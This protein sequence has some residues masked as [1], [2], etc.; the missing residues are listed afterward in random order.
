MT[1]AKATLAVYVVQIVPGMRRDKLDARATNSLNM[2]ENAALES[3]KRVDNYQV[4]TGAR[5]DREKF[6]K[7]ITNQRCELHFAINGI[8]PTDMPDKKH[9]PHRTQALSRPDIRV[10]DLLHLDCQLQQVSVN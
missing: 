8:K 4:P 10:F 2:A 9:N 6:V 1:N 5:K 7:E 3:Y